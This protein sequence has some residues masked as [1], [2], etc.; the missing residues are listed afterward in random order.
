MDEAISD[1]NVY[2]ELE[3]GLIEH[4]TCH[5]RSVANTWIEEESVSSYLEKVRQFFEEEM[6]RCSDCLEGRSR[7]PVYN[8]L[9]K[10]F[11]IE[12]KDAILHK[13]TGL[14]AMLEVSC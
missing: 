5:A 12:K 14:R 7:G 10:V 4:L 1:S 13:P 2:A 9:E 3:K 6:N 11:V 8:I